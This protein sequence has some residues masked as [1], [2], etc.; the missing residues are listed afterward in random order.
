[1]ASLAASSLVD[2]A[3]GYLRILSNKQLLLVAQRDGERTGFCA[4]DYGHEQTAALTVLLVDPRT[5][6]Q[7]IGTKLIKRVAAVLKANKVRRL[8]L[9]AGK[10]SYFWPGLPAEQDAAWL[11]FTRHGFQ[12]Q[13]SSEDLVRTLDGYETPPWVHARQVANR[14]E[15]RLA[16]LERADQI[17]EFE[18]KYFPMWAQYFRGEMQQGRHENILFAEGPSHNIYGT[19]LINGQGSLPWRE[20]SGKRFGTLNTLGVAPHKRGQGI[21][22]ALT[23]KAMTLLQERGC[24]SC[25]IQWT[26]LANWYGKLGATRHAH[27]RMAYK[28][29]LAARQSTAAIDQ[30]V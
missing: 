17:N 23:A 26:G 18:H 12:E 25:Y 22:L 19:V 3:S 21:G 24:S 5:H 30:L 1:M 14:T 29:M 4:V 16:S 11:F 28:D 2:Y 13:E 10:S 9:G 7:G 6:R 15:V 8:E 27:Y 20:H